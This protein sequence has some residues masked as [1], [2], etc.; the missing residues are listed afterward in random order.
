MILEPHPKFKVIRDL[1]IDFDRTRAPEMD[2]R[3]Q[4]K[5]TVDPDKCDGC[6]DC[7]FICPIG[8]Y[9]LQKK[10][11]GAVSVPVDITNCCGEVCSQCSIF[12]KNTAILIR[13]INDGDRI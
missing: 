3:P 5:I 1:A 2:A 12:C 4:V 13:D 9:D 8:V 11:E 7:V 10:G 6:R